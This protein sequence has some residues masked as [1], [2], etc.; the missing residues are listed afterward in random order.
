MKLQKVGFIGFGNVVGKLSGSL[1]RNGC[2]LLLRNIGLFQDI[3]MTHSV[4]LEITPILI[5]ISKDGQ[6]LFGA[7]E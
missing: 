7:R 2:D 4:P 5:K 1:I 6:T 3:A